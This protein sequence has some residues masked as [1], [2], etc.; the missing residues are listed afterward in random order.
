VK[1]RYPHD[2]DALDDAAY[3]LEAEM[4]NL[5]AE[6]QEARSQRGG[7]VS[8]SRET[9]ISTLYRSLLKKLGVVQALQDSGVF[10]I[11]PKH[12]NDERGGTPSR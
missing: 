6:I 10:N 3:Q 7:Q 9:R 5:R 11:L 1:A 8:L 4:V 2:L 12:S